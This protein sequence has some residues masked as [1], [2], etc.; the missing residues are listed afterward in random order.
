MTGRRR[1]LL[2]TA[3]L[4]AAVPVAGTV[5]VAQVAPSRTRHVIVDP[6]TDISD[7]LR[8]AGLANDVFA[9]RVA[10]RR[11]QTDVDGLPETRWTVEVLE[12]YKGALG[13]GN[14]TVVH[15]LG[16]HDWW[17]RVVVEGDAVL[18]PGGTYLF[19]TMTDTAEGRRTLVPRYGDRPFAPGDDARWRRAVAEQVPYRPGG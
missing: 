3:S 19:A 17:T 4:A 10:A 16:G 1:V 2:L 11:G 7:D 14:T 18:E 15:Q 6:V 12:V 13:A 8:L 9:G 5:A